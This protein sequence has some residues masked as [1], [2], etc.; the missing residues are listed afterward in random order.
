LQF[1]LLSVGQAFTVLDLAGG[2]IDRFLKAGQAFAAFLIA[3]VELFADVGQFLADVGEFLP[4][5]LHV[6]E[7]ILQLS[8]TQGKLF[9][10]PS[11]IG[12]QGRGQIQLVPIGTQ[13]RDCK[14]RSRGMLTLPASQAAKKQTFHARSLRNAIP[15]LQIPIREMNRHIDNGV[16]LRKSLMKATWVR[17]RGWLG[18]LFYGAALGLGYAGGPLFAQ[19]LP[20]PSASTAVAP[21]A[22]SPSELVPDVPGPAASVFAGV[23]GTPGCDPCAP[24]WCDPICQVP[25][26]FGGFFGRTL[27]AGQDPRSLHFTGT[28][29]GAEGNS[30]FF[31]R[32][33]VTVNGPKGPYTL[34][35]NIPASGFPNFTLSQ[36]PQLTALVRA[37]FPG[38]TFVD[39]GGFFFNNGNSADFF[40]DYLTRQT[41]VYLPN[42]AGGGLV[43]RNL[44]FEN[45]SALPQDRVYFFY[46]A[47]GNFQLPDGQTLNINRYVFGG[48]K[49]FFG[50][51]ASVEVRIP[52][53]GTLNNDQSVGQTTSFQNTEFGNIGLAFKGLIFRSPNFAASLGLGVSLPTAGSS[54]LQ[55]AGSPLVEIQNR[56][57]LI[58]PMLGLVW[59]P[60]DRFYSQLGL[61]FDLDP[62]GNPVQALN[63]GGGLSQI[64]TLKDQ[65]YAFLS[66]AAG[67]WIYRGRSGCLTGIALQ[68]ELDYYRSFGPLDVVQSTEFTVANAS[69]LVNMLNVTPGAIFEFG[70]RTR[71]SVG[72]SV[73]VT[74]DRLYDWVLTAQLNYN[75]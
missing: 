23:P 17:K 41:T 54:Q 65:G 13:K 12:R 6:G 67:Y 24:C 8:L 59:A 70:G 21:P 39:G 30:S 61:Q 50:G 2:P 7:L 37:N 29:T 58:Q 11:E 52:F 33:P 75:F 9:F 31:I 10:A 16:P 46:N 49:T 40:Y 5:P 28:G 35:N 45:G 26:M 73:P 55:V 15:A 25:N 68:G 18:K 20:P 14:K 19:T 53:A 4:L 71:L 36:N 42:P 74:G 47:V 3:I 27:A 34:T 32:G 66:G 64:G 69:S 51:N 48:E 38:A 63:S 57:C 1:L 22:A 43:G 62:F 72:V 44:Y 56:T 60:N